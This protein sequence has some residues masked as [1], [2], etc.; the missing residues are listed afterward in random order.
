LREGRPEVA[1]RLLGHWWTVEGRVQAGDKRGRTIG[2][3]TANVSLEG[4]LEP[5]LGVYAVRVEIDGKTYNGVANYGRRPTFDKKDLL[6]E[7]HIFDFAGDLYGHQIVVAFI[8]Y[9]RP[10]LKFA[11]LDALKTQIAADSKH[12]RELLKVT[13]SSPPPL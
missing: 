8:A 2:F 10:E 13:S 12:S 9:L 4:Y 1:A 6:L 7:V 5:A 11:G 3:P